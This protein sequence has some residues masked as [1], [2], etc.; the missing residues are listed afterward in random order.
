MY[1]IQLNQIRTQY[2][3]L[4]EREYYHSQISEE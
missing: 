4:T 2:I 1:I 3:W